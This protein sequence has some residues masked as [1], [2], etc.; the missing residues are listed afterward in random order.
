MAKTTENYEVLKVFRDKETQKRYIVGAS[1]PGDSPERIAELQGAGYLAAE[2][3]APDAP[4]PAE[5]KG[6][7]GE[8]TPDAND[9]GKS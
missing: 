8:V 4:K 7:A 1:F 2:P 6:K 9:A 3:Q 5:K